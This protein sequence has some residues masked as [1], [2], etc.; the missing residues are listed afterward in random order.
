MT[1]HPLKLSISPMANS[2]FRLA[3]VI[4]VSLGHSILGAEERIV[5]HSNRVG[6]AEIYVSDVDGTNLVRLTK[7][8]ASDSSPTCSPDGTKIAFTSNRAGS[9]EIFIMNSDGT[10]LLRLTNNLA[11]D[12]DPCW[13]PDGSKIAFS[14]SRDGNFE[15]YVMD[16]EGNN[17]VRLT[18]HGLRDDSPC[19]S[20]D[21]GKIAFESSRDGGMASSDIFV[22]DDDGKN[23]TNLTINP[24]MFL[25]RSPAW[26][27]DGE[28]IAFQTRRDGDVKPEVYVMN[29]KGKMHMRLTDGNGGSSPAWSSDGSKIAFTS[30]RDRDRNIYVMDA[31]GANI[32]RLTKTVPGASDS[33]PCWQTGGTYAVTPRGKWNTSWG[34]IKHKR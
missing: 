14:S 13:S 34:T 11:R 23:P 21:G 3:I 2:S 12:I 16:A 1:L 31:D 22:M 17:P 6:N 7:N 10:S 27:P 4:L 20:P 24:E 5:F 30:N 8:P 9:Y 29:P 26:S 32:V 18:H 15:I 28:K 19:W 25:N 33:S